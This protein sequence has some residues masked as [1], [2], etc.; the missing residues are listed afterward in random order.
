ME[1]PDSDTSSLWLEV[2]LLV[3]RLNLR[4]HLPHRGCNLI[5]SVLKSIFTRLGAFTT[6]DK[7]ATTLTTTFKQLG[8][9]NGFDVI[10]MCPTCRRVYPEDAPFDL[11]CCDQP[12]F[13]VRSV[14]Q[15]NFDGTT[16]T[17]ESQT[18]EPV[19][20]FPYRPIT[21]QLKEVI[22]RDGMEDMLD[23]WRSKRRRD[24]IL[25][26]IMDGEVWRTLE[27]PDGQPFFDNSPNRTRPDELRIGLTLLFDG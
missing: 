6:A 14:L 16:A 8:L 17:V 3:S 27:G 18:P 1:S 24:G 22:S 12:I 9:E 23:G 20:K 11:K 26:D 21:D 15:G 4:F 13:K 10:P 19:L 25:D 2:L 7:P 5:L